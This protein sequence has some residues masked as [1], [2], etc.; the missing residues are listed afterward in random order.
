MTSNG[1]R[2]RLLFWFQWS[3]VSA[4]GWLCGLLMVYFTEPIMIHPLK[5]LI[6]AVSENSQEM[7]EAFHGAMIFQYGFLQEAHPTDYIGVRLAL[8]YGLLFGTIRGAIF[9]AVGG[10]VQS[11]MLRRYLPIKF[12]WIVASGFAWAMIWGVFGGIASAWSGNQL[13]H[14]LAKEAQ[15]GFAGALLL[16]CLQ[17]YVLRQQ[18]PKA[19]RWIIATIASWAMIHTVSVTLMS[20]TGTPI[21][22]LNAMLFGICHGAITV[23]ALVSLTSSQAP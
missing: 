14:L 18:M 3:A 9:G 19:Y 13:D 4:L 22:T 20:Q 6:I 23:L 12:G 10:A 7:Y 2:I 11:L 21:M 17:W 15:Y 16:G 1:F 8:R 5:S